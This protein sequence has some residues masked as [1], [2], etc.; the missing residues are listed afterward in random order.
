MQE[1]MWQGTAYKNNIFWRSF[2]IFENTT[3]LQKLQGLKM[4]CWARNKLRAT[5]FMCFWK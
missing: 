3:I 4:F 2:L 5:Q 1:F